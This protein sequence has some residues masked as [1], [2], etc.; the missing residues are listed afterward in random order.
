MRDVINMLFVI[1][2]C[3]AFF[4]LCKLIEQIKKAG[5]KNIEMCLSARKEHDDIWAYESL[6]TLCMILMNLLIIGAWVYMHFF[7]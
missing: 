3:G 1:F 4:R 5:T 6:E 7:E 2:A